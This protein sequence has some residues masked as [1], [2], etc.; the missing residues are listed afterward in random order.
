MLNRLIEYIGGE[1]IHIEELERGGLKAIFTIKALL[2][3]HHLLAYMVV[4]GVWRF[5]S[6][7]EIVLLDYTLIMRMRNIRTVF[8]DNKRKR[9]LSPFAVCPVEHIITS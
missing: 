6:Q 5:A 4:D 2:T 8:I 7:F 1:V 9:Q 3:C